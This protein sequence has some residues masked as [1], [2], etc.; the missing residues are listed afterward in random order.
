MSLAAAI[1][2]ADSRVEAFQNSMMSTSAQHGVLGVM[3]ADA[4]S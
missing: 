1:D 3:A 2:A 4:R